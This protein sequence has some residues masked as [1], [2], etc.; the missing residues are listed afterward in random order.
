MHP[1]KEI[2]RNQKAGIKSGICSVCSANPFVLKASLLKAKKDDNYVL[3]EATCNQVNQFGGYTGMKPQDFK[4][5]VYELADQIGIDREKIILGGDHLGPNVWQS[6]KA[7]QAMDWAKTMVRD[8]VL[9]GFTKIHLDASMPLADDHNLPLAPEII[10]E[11]GAQL[12]Q[13][14][15]EAYQELKKTVPTAVEPVYIIG[16]EVP[17]P[18]GMQAESEE[19]TVTKVED[20]K[21]TVELSKQY[22][23][24]YNLEKAWD[25]VVAVVVQPGVE[26]GDNVIM[27]Y[28]SNQARELST[29]LT[30]YDNLVFEGHSTDY[31]TPQGLAAMIEGGIA[32]L[33]VGP[34]LTFAAREALYALAMIEDEI[35]KYDP[36]VKLSRLIEI[37]D[38]EMVE[39]PSNW[40]KHYH[41]KEVEVRLN[42][43]YSFLDRSRYYL[44][45]EAVEDAIRRLIANLSLNEIP[46]SMISQYLP[47]QYKRLRAGLIE[48]TPEAFVIDKIMGA[49]EDYDI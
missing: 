37:L 47:E 29:A 21:E 49:L 8:Y 1:I 3:I 27:E 6:E 19:L 43:K 9:A 26:F 16:T 42:R 28:D 46:L 12:C 25:N 14:A 17:T 22:F 38:M 41:G 15:E 13:A 31:Q 24:K 20:F 44:A 2:V 35:Y 40:Q 48:N 10:A 18:G 11:R 7:D 32:I 45:T 34:A 33:K 23:Q 39:N 30:E 5:L 36:N 4:N